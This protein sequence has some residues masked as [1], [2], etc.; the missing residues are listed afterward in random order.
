MPDGPTIFLASLEHDMII[1]PSRRALER[2]I[3]TRQSGSSILSDAKFQPVRNRIS[4]ATT[5]VVFA[6]PQRCA[7]I[8]ELFMGAEDLAEARPWIDAMDDTVVSLVLDHSDTE[9]HLSALI[10]NIPDVGELVSAKIMDQRHLATTR[11][12]ERHLRESQQ[13]AIESAVRQG[14]WSQAERAVNQLHEG[15]PESAEALMDRFN[16]AAA[17]PDDATGAA[18]LG[19]K[20]C[21]AMQDDPLE[22]N[23]F[24]WALLTED[25]Y[26]GRFAELALKASRRSNEM[27]G[28]RNWAYVDTLAL[29]EFVNGN[30]ERAVDLERRAIELAEGRGEPD[31]SQSLARFEAALQRQ[32]SHE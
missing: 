25:R 27:T 3:Q 23:N 19:E 29:A 9:F 12:A 17:R 31:L 7:R 14:D 1:S 24:A 21:D 28:Q 22:L 30:V 10:G 26:Q 5:K 4:D 16:V 18:A 15:R 11:H 8:G 20:L 32:A 6:H 2:A 13:A